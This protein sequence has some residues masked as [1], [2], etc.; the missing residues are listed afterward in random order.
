[1]AWQQ[2]CTKSTEP[3]AKASRASAS[4]ALLLLICA[5][6]AAFP[7]P[8]GAAE[9]GAV[10]V[11]ESGGLSPTTIEATRVAAATQAATVHV[12]RSGSLRLMGVTRD[13]IDVQR[14]EEGFGYPMS[15]LAIDGADPLME[16][17]VL[18]DLPVDGVVMSERSARL[19]GA[20]PGDVVELEG[21][22]RR[23]HE[24]TIIDVVPDEALDWYELVLITG[25]ADAL[26][27]DRASAM[28]VDSD[29]PNA[30][31]SALRWFAR[32]PTVRIGSSD[33]PI[34]FTDP[35]LPTVVVKERF[36]EFSFRPTGSGDGIEMDETW[37]AENIVDVNIDGLGP[38]RC[39]RAVV[40]YLRAAVAD[41]ERSGLM[42]VV[43]YTDFQLAGG[44]FNA[45][46]MRGGDKGYALSRHAWGIAIDFNP[47]TNPYGGPTALT[48]GFGDVLRRWGF[49]WGAT[50]TVPDGMHFEWARM[51]DEIRACT[52]FRLSE[53]GSTAVTWLVDVS[54]SAC[55]QTR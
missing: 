13:G 27:F 8:A 41:L 24:M 36:G 55:S 16:P 42:E 29:D 20:Q 1:M 39:N 21:W 37:L 5:Q 26:E 52:P 50:W 46:M 22:N 6:V 40:P 12:R 4:A 33:H 28:V 54:T 48:D 49:S 14:P 38:F 19:R 7:V 31:I 44:C 51:P 23:V 2:S 15:T 43:D 18:E 3:P 34:R 25:A 11:W 35:T 30:M 45:R 47:S 10:I 9:P 53:P 17:D 32:S